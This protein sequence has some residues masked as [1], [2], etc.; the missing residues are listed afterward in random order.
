MLV[1]GL[2]TWFQL[3]PYCC[4]GIDV[5]LKSLGTV[6]GAVNFSCHPA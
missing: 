6:L 5:M 3:T 1:V 2:K 4:A